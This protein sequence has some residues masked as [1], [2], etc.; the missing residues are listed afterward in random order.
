MKLSNQTVQTEI[1]ASTQIM[2]QIN[3][4][5]TQIEELTKGVDARTF[6]PEISKELEEKSEQMK[7]TLNGLTESNKQIYITL[8]KLAIYEKAVA[9]SERTLEF[10]PAKLTILQDEAKG[11]VVQFIKQDNFTLTDAR[12]KQVV[13]LYTQIDT[14]MSNLEKENREAIEMKNQLFTDLNEKRTMSEEEIENKLE[15]IQTKFS[16]LESTK[17][18]ITQ[19]LETIKKM[20]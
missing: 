12:K 18:Q 10:D 17:N 13:D 1:D 15:T 9:L 7:E 5:K 19:N 8:G 16:A 2:V 11:L 4:V 3:V 20:V 14:S 6:T